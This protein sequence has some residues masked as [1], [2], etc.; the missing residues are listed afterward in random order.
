MPY[1]KVVCTIVLAEI[2]FPKARYQLDM[3][4]RIHFDCVAVTICLSVVSG[5]SW[6]QLAGENMQTIEGFQ[7]SIPF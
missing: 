1:Q 5:R 3:Q 4:P 2:R 7:V 6:A